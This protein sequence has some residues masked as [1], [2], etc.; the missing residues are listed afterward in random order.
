M[1]GLLA[2]SSEGETRWFRNVGKDPFILK[3][4]V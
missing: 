3:Y 4:F 1:K 2:V